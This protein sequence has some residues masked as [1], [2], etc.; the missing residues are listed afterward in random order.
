M[1]LVFELFDNRQIG[2]FRQ[3]EHLLVF[4]SLQELQHLLQENY[5]V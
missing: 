3:R 1:R 4:V 5:V 2:L